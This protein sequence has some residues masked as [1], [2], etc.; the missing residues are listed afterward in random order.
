MGRRVRLDYWVGIDSRGYLFLFGSFAT[1][2]GG[3]GYVRKK[4]R[5]QI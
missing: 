1:Y 5:H 3:G 2:F 4:E